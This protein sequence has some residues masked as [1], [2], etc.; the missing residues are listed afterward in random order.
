MAQTP[1]A[2]GLERSSQPGAALSKVRRV[3]ILLLAIGVIA[4]LI[5][6]S[7]SIEPRAI[8][9]AEALQS[10]ESRVEILVE[11]RCLDSST[12]VDVE[13]TATSIIV[14]ASELV[15]NDDEA[16]CFDNVVPEIMMASETIELRSEV[17]ERELLDGHTMNPAPIQPPRQNCRDCF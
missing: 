10:G 5:P 1:A 17:G 6:R 16:R 7:P 14:T 3:A 13:E 2:S 8:S 12:R 9:I 11:I 4:V 15:P